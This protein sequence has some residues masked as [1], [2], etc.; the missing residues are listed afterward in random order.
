ME[1]RDSL[2]GS[3]GTAIAFLQVSQSVQIALT[4]KLGSPAASLGALH[5]DKRSELASLLDSEGFDKKRVFLLAADAVDF[6]ERAGHFCFPA[7][8]GMEGIQILPEKERLF[9]FNCFQSA[10]HPVPDGL[11][12]NQIERNHIVD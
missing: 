3:L 12:G 2:I 7:S 9:C 1:R 8:P 11:P 6:F 5:G 10:A 4:D